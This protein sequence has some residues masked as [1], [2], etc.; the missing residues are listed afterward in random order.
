MNYLFIRFIRYVLPLALLLSTQFP[1][2]ATSTETVIQ[3]Q[4]RKHLGV[5][6]KND[7]IVQTPYSG[8]YEVQVGDNLVYTDKQAQYLFIG[9]IMNIQTKKDYTDERLRQISIVNFSDLPKDLAI[10]VVKGD[11]SRSIAVF[12]D[13]TCRY[14]KQ[15]ENNLRNVD[16]VTIY[17]YPFNIL[18]EKSVEI[19][20]NIWCSDNPAKAWSDWMIHDKIPKKAKNGCTFPNDKILRLGQKLNIRG[21]PAIFFTDGT[22]VPGAAEADEI[23]LKLD[24]LP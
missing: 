1:A 23:N 24:S 5:N 17:L 7:A 2:A 13:P 14:C 11:G 3:Q 12:S 20:T 22:R 19:S 15:L 6:V 21:T 10:R 8:L 9:K 16:D 4:F 18:S